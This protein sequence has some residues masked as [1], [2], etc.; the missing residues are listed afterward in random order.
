[1]ARDGSTDKWLA[2]AGIGSGIA[3]ITALVGAPG[4]VKWGVLLVAAAIGLGFVGMLFML[5]RK[6]VRTGRLSQGAFGMILV[7]GV[8]ALCVLLLVIGQGYLQ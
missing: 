3:G 5:D 1:M 4:G 2:I 6:M 8:V 7:V